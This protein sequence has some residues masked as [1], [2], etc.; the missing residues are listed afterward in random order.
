[1]DNSLYCFPC[2]ILNR[3]SRSNFFRLGFRNNS[4]ISTRMKNDK[5]TTGHIDIL[6]SLNLLVK[7]GIEESLGLAQNKSVSD[8]YKKVK[9][10]L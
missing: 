8:Y 4:C 6:I 2:L 7:S 10:N 3:G 5:C 9:E 1:M